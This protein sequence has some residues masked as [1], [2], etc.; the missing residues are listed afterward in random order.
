M[1]TVRLD[2][3][4]HRPVVVE[5]VS[6]QPG[7]TVAVRRLKEAALLVRAGFGTAL[8]RQTERDCALFD[9][10][11]AAIPPTTRKRA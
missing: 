10:L 4:F 3:D 5:G 9:L 11:A 1:Y 6:H 8:D 2:P 7:E